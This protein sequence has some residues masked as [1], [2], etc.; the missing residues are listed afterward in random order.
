MKSNKCSFKNMINNSKINFV[1]LSKYFLA[2]LGLLLGVA[3]V[4]ISVIGMKLGFDFSG[5]TVVEIVYDVETENVEK[6]SEEAVVEKLKEVL[7]QSDKNLKIYSYQSE[8]SSFGPKLTFKVVGDEKISSTEAEVLKTDLFTSLEY[9]EDNIIQKEYVKTYNVEATAINTAVYASIALSVAIVLLFLGVFARYGLSQ[10][11]TILITS[12]SSVL[13]AFAFVIICRIYVDTS[14]IA[15]VLS[16]FVINTIAT[17][18]YFDRLR[19]IQKDV[20]YKDYSRSEC[21]NLALKECFVTELLVF[22][23]ALVSMALVSGLG[24]LQIRNFG[25]PTL[26][27]TAITFLSVYFSASYFFTIIKL[28]QK[29]K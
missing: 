27:G 5:G 9:S 3:I 14:F 11:L 28:N 25:L 29:R 2:T 17:L 13:I 23:V 21:A 24:I 18:I 22:V 26:F 1:S 6:Y 15:S 12:I 7:A 10:A 19:E 16:V 20:S 8:E 4:I